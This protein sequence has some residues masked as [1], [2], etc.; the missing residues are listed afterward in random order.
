MFERAK[1]WLRD[2]YVGEIKQSLDLTPD[3][4]AVIQDGNRRYARENGLD[5]SDGHAR[6]AE[7]TEDMLHWC[8]EFDISEVTLYTFSTENFAR[9]DEE[10]IDLF[11]LIEDR[12]YS[13]A[14]ADLVHDNGV[15]IHGL[16]EIQRLPDRVVDAV[17]Y[18]EERTQ[19]YETLKLNIALAYGGRNELLRTAQRLTR[20]VA[21]GELEPDAITAETIGERLYRQ[22]VQDVDLV[23]RTG[24]DER[25]SNFLPWHASG[26][27]AAVYFCTPYWPEFS[28]VEFARAIRTYEAREQSWQETQLRRALSL[29]RAVRQ[30]EYQRRTQ[31]IQRLRDQLS[32]ETATRFVNTVR[33]D[34]DTTTEDT[35]AQQAQSVPND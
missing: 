16:G 29:V 28:K 4:V 18:A 24:G 31:L 35:E 14:D 10:L 20:E 11:D 12:L 34:T 26:N 1:Q 5:P 15:S 7:T 30:T 9:P 33:T 23:I 21:D 8:S 6:G 27:E 32:R 25:T 13:F 3:H 17:A 2:V 19:Q 22:P